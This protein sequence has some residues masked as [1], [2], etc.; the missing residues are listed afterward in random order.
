MAGSPPLASNRRFLHLWSARLIAR[1]GSA[2]GYVVLLW[3]VFAETGSALAVV[4]V[5]LAEF[6]PTVAVG[7]LSGAVVDRYERR[8]VV[9][10]STMAR[11]AAMGALVL[12][13]RLVGFDL[14]VIVVAA[15]VFSV[16]GTFYGPGTQ[17]LLPEVVR[18]EQIDRANGLL[19]SS[20][21]ILGIVGSAVAGVLVL[22]VG[23]VPSLGI[24]AASYVVAG[25]FVALIGVTVAPA[26]RSPASR[27]ML[28]EVRDGLQY[29]GRAT[30]L[31]QL[32]VSSLVNNLLW[33]VV[34]TFLVVYTSVVLHGS[35]LVYGGLEAVL[36]GGW[37][38]G[39]LLVGR[40]GLTRYTGRIAALT[41]FVE[42]GAILGMVFVP[43]VASA[44]ALVLAVGLWQGVLNVAWAS[45]VQAG[46]PQQLQGRYFATDTALSYAAIPL[47]QI[48]GG[49]LIVTLGL[50]ATFLLVGLGSAVA[51]VGFLSLARLRALG[52]DPRSPDRFDL[53]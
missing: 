33:S 6:L 35:A 1:F 19:E 28:Q 53:S 50:P 43:R 12:T 10:L 39:G 21:S 42:G 3:Y 40:L 9:V 15:A 20:E 30:G 46:V 38:A 17:A 24:D 27:G 32:T 11:G 18:R 48:A 47:S 37:G 2:L 5:G 13:L 34:L 51:S 44:L 16:C 26:K 22:S 4:Y 14:P 45:T 31:L 41:G 23:A 29:L 7:V 8:R 36:A 25:L 49:L 52:Y